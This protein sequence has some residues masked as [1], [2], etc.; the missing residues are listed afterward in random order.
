MRRTTDSEFWI[1]DEN[2]QKLIDT[3]TEIFAE[4]LAEV[5]GYTMTDKRGPNAMIVVGGLYDIVSEVPPE[6][7]GASRIYLSAVGEATLVIEVRDSLS[8]A[9][10]FRGIDRSKIESGANTMVEAN[11]VTAWAEVRRWA[12]RW[13]G[14]LRTGLESIHN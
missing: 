8:G 13:G 12:R 10:I 5:E 2:R 11:P 4:E 9:T 1:S 3:V 7:I 6:Y 14:R